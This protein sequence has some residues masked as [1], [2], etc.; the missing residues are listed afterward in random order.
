MPKWRLMS[1]GPALSWLLVLAEGM[2]APLLPAPQRP[3]ATAAA[4]KAPD[5]TEPS[6]EQPGEGASEA[7]LDV[8]TLDYHGGGAFMRD[9]RG[10]RV[11]LGIEPELQRFAM[12]QLRAAKPSRGAVVV[13]RVKDGQML[14]AADFPPHTPRSES[15]LWS[16]LTPS[17][18]L[19][20]L[21]TTAAL[22]E[23]AHLAPDH[24]V[25]SLGGEHRIELA[26]LVAPRGGKIRCQPFSTIMAT[27]RNAAYARLVA[28]HLTS[29][30]ISN[31]ADRFGFGEKDPRAPFLEFG[32]YEPSFGQLAVARTAAGFIGS[33]LSAVGAAHLALIVAS[34]G[35]RLPIRLLA[36][37]GAPASEPTLDGLV[38]PSVEQVLLPETARRLREMMES[39]VRQGTAYPAFF[40]EQGVPLL[41]G[42]RVAGKT[43][44]LGHE[45]G[46]HSW[47]VG[48]APSRA[49][50]IVVAVLLDNGAVWRTTAKNIGASVFKA[51]FFENAQSEMAGA[52]SPTRDRSPKTTH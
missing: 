2:A 34:G 16:A 21:V 5:G 22:I 18:S 32:R 26:Q 27:S 38:E 45:E 14:A 50:E 7:L 10:R 4:S 37:E 51:Y 12:A 17:A 31:F 19:F 47:F 25:C 13:L 39:V 41:P 1:L 29:E 48:F 6:R 20:K 30:D 11:K 40:D 44:T 52:T 8:S 3:H 23:R 33:S 24:R 49:P 35:K 42:L 43:G 28:S 15:V 46:T 9:A 36:A